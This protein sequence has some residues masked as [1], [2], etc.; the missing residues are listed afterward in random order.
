LNKKTARNLR[1]TGLIL[2]QFDVVLYESLWG[3]IHLSDRGVAARRLVFSYRK[4]L[5]LLYIFVFSAHKMTHCYLICL[6][7]FILKHF[8][9]FY[10]L[11]SIYLLP[12]YSA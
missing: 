5:N 9:S 12:F 3:R 10:P 4:Q 7:L 11:Q 1:T 6:S 2:L 8:Y